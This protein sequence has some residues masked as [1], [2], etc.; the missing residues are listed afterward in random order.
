M[1][2]VLFVCLGNICR[3]PMAEAI[4]Q[5]LLE[6]NAQTK[7]WSCDSAGTS[8]YHPGERPDRRTLQVLNKYG[9]QTQHRARQILHH[10]FEEF[11]YLIAMD[12]QHL[13]HMLRMQKSLPQN[14]AQILR[15]IDF[16]SDDQNPS[17]HQEIP[18][19]YYGDLSDFEAVYQLLK[20]GCENLLSHI[21]SHAQAL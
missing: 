11:S 2:R 17:R 3:S 4:F 16:I 15:M 18:D 20:P 14:Q 9:I 8:N 6:K 1:N 5:N 7:A 19:P 10:D 21:L 13:E 12:D